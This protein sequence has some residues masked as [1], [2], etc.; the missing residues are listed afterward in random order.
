MLDI[1]TGDGHALAEIERKLTQWGYRPAVVGTEWSS[2]YPLPV[3]G[4]VRRGDITRGSDRARMNVV[5]DS[6]DL[7]L[8]DNIGPSPEESIKVAAYLVRAG[9]MLLVTFEDSDIKYEREHLIDKLEHQMKQVPGMTVMRSH[10]PNDYLASA[11]YKRHAEAMLIGSRPPAAPTESAQETP[12]P[13]IMVVDDNPTFRAL[14]KRHLSLAGLEKTYEIVMAEDGLKALEQLTQLHS[15]HRTVAL[16][17]HD[18]NMPNM[19]GN[20]LAHTLL[21]RDPRLP[22]IIQTTNPELVLQDLREKS[23]I[24]VLNKKEIEKTLGESVQTLLNKFP[25]PTAP[26]APKNSENPRMENFAGDDL[27]PTDMHGEHGFLR[28][29]EVRIR[30]LAYVQGSGKPGGG[31]Q[32]SKPLTV[33]LIPSVDEAIRRESMYRGDKS[34][35]LNKAVLKFDPRRVKA[36]V[37]RGIDNVTK[38]TTFVVTAEVKEIL[39]SAKRARGASINLLV[40]SVLYKL[41]FGKYKTESSIT[42]HDRLN[43][44]LRES[45]NQAMRAATMYRGDLAKIVR[46]AIK[47]VP[48]KG[49]SGDD[50][51]SSRETVQIQHS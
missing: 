5:T 8:I 45:V 10:V 24:I 48:R 1:K 40:N 28:R 41:F 29:V 47:R 50:L 32:P 39:D 43:V 13:V 9:G 35:M 34:K 21:D 2:Q 19:N 18:I 7:V 15:D 49:I 30:K 26:A 12:K 27:Y 31:Q 33:R 42:N 46:D 38:G 44:Q 17:I 22:I 36:I 23:N 16:V 14:L 6:Q 37:L 51:N 25:Q 11:V 20:E 3:V 4:E